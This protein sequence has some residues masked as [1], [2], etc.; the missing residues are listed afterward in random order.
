VERRNAQRKDVR[1]DRD[2]LER[3]LKQ[4]RSVTRGIEDVLYSVSGRGEITF[5]GGACE[6]ILGRSSESL[7]GRPAGEVA[8]LAGASQD[9][10]HELRRVHE[11]AVKNREAF[12]RCEFPV[13]RAGPAGHME[14]RE[15]VHY[16]RTGKV[17]GITGV[18]RDITDRKRAEEALRESEETYRN[19]VERANDG[20]VMI[21]QGTVVYVNPAL[22]R[23]LRRTPTELLG[24]E[25]TLHVHPDDVARLSDRYGHRLAGVDV[26]AVYEASL[27]ARDASRV[28]VE[29][30]ASLVTHRGEPADLVIVRDI[31]E[32][33]L[34]QAQRDS[35]VAAERE[36]RLV[37]ET[38][39]DVSLALTSHTTLSEVLAEILSQARRIVPFRAAN[40]ALL[41]GD[42]LHIARAQGYE[43]LSL[44]NAVLDLIQPLD[45]FVLD[46]EAIHSQHAVV[47][48][49]VREDSRWVVVPEASWIR[50]YI[51][52]PIR[53]R[54][55]VLGLLRLDGDKPGAFTEDDARHLMPLASAAAVALENAK[56]HEA[57]QKELAERT[58]VEENLRESNRKIERLHEAARALSACSTEDEICRSSVRA[59][60]DI[61]DFSLCTLDLVEG[62]KLVVKATSR[63]LPSGASEE[64]P[65]DEGLAGKTYLTGMTQVFGTLDEAPEAKPTRQE[66]QSGISSP[67]GRLGVFQA[68]STRE[69][70]F[71]NED[72]RLLELL[73]G[74]TVEALKRIRLQQE[75]KE[76][77]IRDP[78]T[79]T[80]N[81]RYFS[82]VIEQEISRSRRYAHPVGLVMI[83]VDRLK[84]V[85]DRFGHQAGDR[86]LQEVARLLQGVVRETDIVIRYGGD[87][88]LIVLPETDGEAEIVAGRIR[89]AIR[90]LNEENPLLPGR[91]PVTLAVGTGHWDPTSPRSVETLLAEVDQRMY[92]NKREQRPHNWPGRSEVA[93]SAGGGSGPAG[94]TIGS[95]DGNTLD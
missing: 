91:L 46:A 72:A 31:R 77:A 69:N 53:L 80:Y 43:P 21:Q 95:C 30:N 89:E 79:S 93:A 39:A 22:A 81:R 2:A 58:Q 66:F 86:V 12:L 49:D 3:E 90:R 26:P 94:G 10:V 45:G 35:L 32:R 8:R 70:A 51:A 85:N 18:V 56:L 13:T 14:V 74:H 78:L 29:L 33:R 84:D 25:F 44:E 41:Q 59:A 36:Q 87:E 11:K 50:T 40:I 23:V 73:L 27:L 60:E 64:S 7:I 88:F 62:D 19:L 34:A 55:R 67:I 63:E 65:L 15:Q 83:D 57:A 82:E 6:S 20:V 68:V 5:I 28:D 47:I 37:A 48:R 52:I 92:E 42:T 9:S 24:T 71:T 75:L 16:D 1:G 38:L 76:Q 17:T 4:L 54:D 61:L